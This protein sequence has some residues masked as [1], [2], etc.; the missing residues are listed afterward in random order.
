MAKKKTV[1]HP[2]AERDP[3]PGGGQIVIYRSDDGLVKLDVR[4]VNET[5]WLAQSD[6]AALFQCSVDNISLHLKNIYDEGELAETATAEDFSVVR[7]EGG[8]SVRRTLKLYNLDAIISVGYRVKSTIATRFRIWATQRLREYIVKGFVMDDE[9]LKNPPVQGSA[10]PVRSAKRMPMN[11]P[12]ASV[13]GL[14]LSDAARLKHRRN[15]II[16]SSWK[17]PQNSFQR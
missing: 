8:R 9:R 7:S 1:K 2:F 4:L 5:L 17:T 10:V 12:K 11:L 3:N 16:S 15:R 14:R 6:M 13:T